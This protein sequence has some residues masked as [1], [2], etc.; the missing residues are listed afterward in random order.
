MRDGAR[1]SKLHFT[2]DTDGVMVVCTL[3]IRYWMAFRR[4]HGL[5]V[6]STHVSYSDGFVS[7]RCVVISYRLRLSKTDHRL[8]PKVG[9]GL[10]GMART[11]IS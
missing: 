5:Q 3:N 8:S 7:S 11:T 2:E 4:I 6:Y 10:D 1:S 9:L